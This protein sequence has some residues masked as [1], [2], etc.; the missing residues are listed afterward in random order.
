MFGAKLF[1]V[2]F[3]RAL[4]YLFQDVDSFPGAMLEKNCELVYSPSNAFAMRRK[5]IYEQLFAVRDVYFSLFFGTT[6]WTNKQ[7]PF[8][9]NSSY[10]LFDLDFL[11]NSFIVV[12]VRFANWGISLGVYPRIFPSFSWGIFDHVMR[13]DQSC[14]KKSIGWIIMMNRFMSCS[15]YGIFISK[16]ILVHWQLFTRE[17]LNF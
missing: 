9:C 6:L 13:L 14:A 17:S 4:Y 1:L 12:D 5:N 10:R 2:I 16:V 7:A 15:S 8:F 3:L 11:T